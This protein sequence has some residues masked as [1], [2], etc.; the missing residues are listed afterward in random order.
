MPELIDCSCRNLDVFSDTDEEHLLRRFS[1]ATAIH[2]HE[3]S[4]STFT[5][6]QPSLFIGLRKLSLHNNQLKDVSCICSLINLSWLSLHYNKL[7][8][9]PKDFGNLQK[10][11]RLSLHNNL[12][13]ELPDSFKY[14]TSFKTLSLFRNYFSDFKD[15]IFENIKNCE[16]LALHQNPY[17]TRLPKS[18]LNMTKLRELWIGQTSI[19][20]DDEVLTSLR[21]LSSIQVWT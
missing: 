4:L 12:L 21:K 2:L 8:C 3:N 9:L 17:L 16:K 10:L 5:I 14:C 6:C 7:T 15:D 19:P 13:T 11:Q 1:N 18:F 20:E